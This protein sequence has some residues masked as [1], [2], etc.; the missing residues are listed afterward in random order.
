MRA[1]CVRKRLATTMLSLGP[2]A[3][4]G[5]F[6]GTKGPREIDEVDLLLE[7]HAAVKF[8]SA[9]A[10]RQTATGSDRRSGAAAK[11]KREGAKQGR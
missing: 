2:T 1:A 11:S 4:Q 7:V 3:R 10:K 6:A 9:F 5:A 8:P